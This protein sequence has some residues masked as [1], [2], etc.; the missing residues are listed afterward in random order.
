MQ[1]NVLILSICFFSS[2]TNSILFKKGV[3]TLEYT[4]IPSNIGPKSNK[5]WKE[6]NL[7]RGLD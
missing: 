7:E 5:T 6:I 4:I 1:H 2:I 3:K